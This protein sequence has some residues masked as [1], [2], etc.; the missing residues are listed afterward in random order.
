VGQTDRRAGNRRPASLNAPT[1]VSGRNNTARNNTACLRTG[2]ICLRCQM[3]KLQA[4]KPSDEDGEIDEEQRAADMALFRQSLRQSLSEGIVR[5]LERE[6]LSLRQ[7]WQKEDAKKAAE[8][9][10]SATSGM[11]DVGVQSDH[12]VDLLVGTQTPRKATKEVVR[13]DKS[14]ETDDDWLQAL[15]FGSEEELVDAADD[16]R[17]VIET[18]ADPNTSE[19][20][21]NTAKTESQEDDTY[22]PVIPGRS[23]S[24]GTDKKRRSSH[25]VHF[26]TLVE[27]EKRGTAPHV[28]QPSANFAS[29]LLLPSPWAARS[30]VAEI[31]QLRL[32]RR[33]AVL[34]RSDEHMVIMEAE[35]FSEHLEDHPAVTPDTTDQCPCDHVITE[36][37][38]ND[39]DRP[40]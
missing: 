30:T 40:I 18:T 17:S 23:V 34:A 32:E 2:E 14:T 13:A 9:R 25:K 12:A 6:R 1:L 16:E 5:L 37:L 29:E 4:L 28:S 36:G 22:R 21:D 20:R 33:R 35:P 11:I 19:P 24:S 7:E 8:E 10:L 3:E 31:D 27:N 26:A 15:T 38:P 39:R